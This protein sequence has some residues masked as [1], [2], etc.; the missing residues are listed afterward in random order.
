MKIVHITTYPGKGKK[1][2]KG[3]GVASYTK[4]LIQN[5]TV[6]ADDEVYVLCDMIDGKREVY[7]ED[8][9]VVKRCFSR[10]PA[11]VGQLRRE[12]KTIE[13]DVIHI[14]QELALFGNVLT[15]YLLQWFL[16]LSRRWPIVL[17]IH[18]V[19]DITAID[20]NFVRENNSRMPAW[21]VKCAFWVIYKP[22]TIWARHIIVH[23][24]SFRQILQDRY[25]VPHQ[26]ISVIPHGVE[27]L[28]AASKKESA[29]KLGIDPAMQTVLFMGYL[30]GYKGLELLIDG[31][32]QF[33]RNNPYAFLLIGA[34][35]HPKL[36]QDPTYLAEYKRLQQKAKLQLPASQYKWVGFIP[37]TQIGDYY[38]ASD[39]SMYP[40]TVSMSSSGPM[41]FAIGYE[42]PFLA[43]DAFT[44][45]FDQKLLFARTPEA[46]S[47]ALGNFFANP[48]EFKAISASLKKARSWQ[49]VGQL[50]YGLYKG[51]TV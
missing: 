42:K 19:V 30:T 33:A 37:E 36:D 40:Y 29:K 34:G 46:L 39:V 27:P 50:T 21:L 15:A 22:L 51:V 45:V 17:T 24:D 8:G 11:F 13:P 6:A 10:S 4:N 49:R 14:Q 23:E 18:G 47:Q 43:S 12:L 31:F 20:K 3:S 7:A 28:R 44:G 35:K 9:I 41:S 2:V 5:T 1:H 16:L 32:A 25:H 38:S 26:K 48:T